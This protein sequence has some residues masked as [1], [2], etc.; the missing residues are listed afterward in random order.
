[1]VKTKIAKKTIIAFQQILVYS[2]DSLKLQVLPE[3]GKAIYDHPFK[4]FFKIANKANSC[5]QKFKVELLKKSKKDK[6]KLLS[7]C[8][9]EKTGINYF[10][11]I[12][13]KENLYFLNVIF[14]N[15]YTKKFQICFKE[16]EISDIKMEIKY[17]WI[18]EKKDIVID[19]T[20]INGFIGDSYRLSLVNIT[21]EVFF[22][23]LK[24]H[25]YSKT[26]NIRRKY[27][28]EIQEGIYTV[29][30]AKK[31]VQILYCRKL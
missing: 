12:L 4:L 18:S 14:C 13:K 23:I 10:E 24:L 17:P 25:F 28:Q 6:N 9:V 31:K 7:F 29:Q 30:L 8:E 16:D 11:M 3:G 22:K 21:K 5:P 19:I 26:T 15:E 27:L 1:M 20:K 2:F